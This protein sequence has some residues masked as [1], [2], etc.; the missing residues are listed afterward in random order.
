M[1]EVG[2]LLLRDGMQGFGDP[3]QGL[4]LFS[5]HAPQIG[6][7][8]LAEVALCTSLFFDLLGANLRLTLLALY[9][10][11]SPL[12]VVHLLGEVPE[13]LLDLGG[14]A[15]TAKDRGADRTADSERGG[16]GLDPLSGVH[17]A[18]FLPLT[19]PAA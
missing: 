7:L 8:T 15:Q 6:D 17:S 9:V 10:L 11:E 1:I 19:A 2:S 14:D 16:S 13:L 12:Q 5:V 18:V 3:I 4:A